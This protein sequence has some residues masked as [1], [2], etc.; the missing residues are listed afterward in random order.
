MPHEWVNGIFLVTGEPYFETQMNQL[1]LTHDLCFIQ[2]M[3]D[4]TN[5]YT[6]VDLSDY[7]YIG[8]TQGSVLFEICTFLLVNHYY[9]D[10]EYITI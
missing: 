1:Y 2:V 6:W 4:M 3:S 5:A 7:V 10:I 8:F 9:N